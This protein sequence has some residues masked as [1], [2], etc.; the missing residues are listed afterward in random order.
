[1]A[2][3]GEELDVNQV[4]PRAARKHPKEET[5]EPWILQMGEGDRWV[6]SPSTLLSA[7]L[8]N[9]IDNGLVG[10]VGEPFEVSYYFELKSTPG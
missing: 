5:A 6:S 1:M 8:D 2:S 10:R 4:E 3:Q 9:I 7:K